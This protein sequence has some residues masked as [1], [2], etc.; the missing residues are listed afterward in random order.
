M[1]DPKSRDIIGKAIKNQ[2]EKWFVQGH[3]GS[4]FKDGQYCKTRDMAYVPAAFEDLL[5][6]LQSDYVDLVCLLGV[7]GGGNLHEG[8]FQRSLRML[9]Q[10]VLHVQKG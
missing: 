8:L 4:V 7:P 2:R 5:T 9:C 3:I 6:R 10:S 1:A